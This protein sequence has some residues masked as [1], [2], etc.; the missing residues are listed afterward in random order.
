MGRRGFF[1]SSS[2]SP[3]S[4]QKWFSHIIPCGIEG[5]AVTSLSLEL[6]RRVTTE[7]VLPHLVRHFES[8][9]GCRVVDEPPDIAKEVWEEAGLRWRQ[10]HHMPGS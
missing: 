3:L 9:L 8:A 10:H 1:S 7:E 6:G 5:K 4:F 2:S